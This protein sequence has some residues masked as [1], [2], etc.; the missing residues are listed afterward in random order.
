[1]LKNFKDN[2]M[3][4][5]KKTI[6]NTSKLIAAVMAVVVIASCTMAISKQNLTGA[7]AATGTD[8]EISWCNTADMSE[9]LALSAGKMID[10]ELSASNEFIRD[11]QS[12]KNQEMS[13]ELLGEVQ[14]IIADNASLVRNANGAGEKNLVLLSEEEYGRVGLETDVV[15]KTDDKSS[16]ENENIKS[17][18]AVPENSTDEVL[19]K[20]LNVEVSSENQGDTTGLEKEE[21][22][23]SE[24]KNSDSNDSAKVQQ[25]ENKEEKQE[26]KKEITTGLKRNEKSEKDYD[27]SDDLVYKYNKKMV[28]DVTDEEYEVLCRIVEAEAGDQDV[29]GRILVANVILNRVRYKKEFANDIIGVVFEKNQFA[30]T[31]DGSYYSVKVSATTMEAVD[32]CL[33]GEDYSQGALYFFMRSATSKSKASWFDTLD[34]LF[35][36]GCHEFF[37]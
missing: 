14:L 26:E 36:Y 13:S 10:T 12:R 35:K 15:K 1:M 5:V 31:R 16:T 11:N 17:D 37:K 9:S 4:T 21:I 34:Y 27:K 18:T 33:Q 8:S 23:I 22:K 28:R 7:E 19:K 32:R 6:G 29:F 20:D 25:K 30:P 3:K 24:N 2:C